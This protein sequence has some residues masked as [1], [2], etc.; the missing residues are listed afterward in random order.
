MRTTSTRGARGASHA[1][2]FYGGRLLSSMSASWF[3]SYA[4]HLHVDA[5]H[6]NWNRASTIRERVS[7]FN[8]TFSYQRYWLDKIMMMDDRK[9]STNEIGL[10][11]IEI[12]KMAKAVMAKNW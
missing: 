10:S 4:Y 5:S 2:A 8:R 11:A 1:F 3:V 9:L 6:T 7:M 12:K